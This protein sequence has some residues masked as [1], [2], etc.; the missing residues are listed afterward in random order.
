MASSRSVR[1]V[2]A[3]AG[4]AAV[5]LGTVLGLGLGTDS[6]APSDGAGAAATPN[7]R[8]GSAGSSSESRPGTSPHQS[9][10]REA[11]IHRG[12]STGGVE[13]QPDIP[14]TTPSS[15]PGIET[16]SSA[17]AGPDWSPL[18]EAAASARG[19]LVTGY[20]RDLLPP[21]PRSSVRT[22]SVAPSP[23][24]VQVA[25]VADRGPHPD[26]VLRFYRE[27]LVRAGFTEDAAPAVGGTSSASFVRDDDVVV[28]TVGG[29]P[30]R[31]YSVYAVLDATQ[32]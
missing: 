26:L 6:R 5:A 30:G 18:P 10:R 29:G 25:L 11:G 8:V 28:V 17:T 14:G 1:A 27:R 7:A 21:A 15:L 20:P 19:G 31:T 4:A 12:G 16:G 24:R 23:D 2:T 3:L 9:L 32:G 22:S 13:V